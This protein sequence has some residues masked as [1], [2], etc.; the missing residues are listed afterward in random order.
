MRHSIR[1]SYKIVS[2]PS[3]SD[4]VLL[5]FKKRVLVRSRKVVIMRNGRLLRGLLGL[6]TG[7]KLSDPSI[8]LGQPL[9]SNVMKRYRRGINND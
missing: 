8:I 7:K 4:I 5:N 3:A 1:T 2:I 6:I 9:T